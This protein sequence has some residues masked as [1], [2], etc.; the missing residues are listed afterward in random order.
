M[1]DSKLKTQH[2][3][4]PKISKSTMAPLRRP[5][6]GARVPNRSAPSLKMWVAISIFLVLAVLFWNPVAVVEAQE[7]SVLENG[8]E[9]KTDESFLPKENGLIVLDSLNSLRQVFQQEYSPLVLT[10]VY[11]SSCPHSLALLNRVEVAHRILTVHFEQITDAVGDHKMPSFAKLDA[12]D[13]D[14]VHLQQSGVFA[15][16]TLVFATGDDSGHAPFVLEYTGQQE[17]AEDI[18]RTVLHYFHQLI[19]AA[20]EVDR[21]DDFVNVK[22]REFRNMMDVTDFMRDQQH[23]ILGNTVVEPGFPST[24]SAELRKY[25]SWLMLDEVADDFVLIVQCRN[26]QSE[27]SESRPYYKSFDH[28]VLVISSRRDRLFITLSECDADAIDGSVVAWKIPFGVAR[29]GER[30]LSVPK[31]TFSLSPRSDESSDDLSLELIEFVVKVSTPSLLWFD[32]QAT[33][34]I[35]FPKYRQ[36]HAVLFVDLHHVEGGFDRP[37]AVKSREMI[38]RFRQTCREHWRKDD[39]AEQ[40]MVCLVVPSTETR[41]LA[42]F[43]IDIWSVLDER[44]QQ[45]DSMKEMTEP[46]PALMLTD[47]RSGGTRRYYLD[48]NA[49]SASNEAIPDFVTNFWQGGLTPHTKSS[50]EGPRTNA[51][52]VRIVTGDSLRSEILQADDDRHA[53]IFFTSPTCGHCKRFSILWNQLAELIAHVEWDSFLTLYQ[54]DVTANDIID[55]DVITVRWLPDV[56]FF[57]S[58]N[59]TNPLRYDVTDEQGEGVGALG[60]P[61]EILHWLIQEGDFEDAQLRQML[62]GLNKKDETTAK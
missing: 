56:Y 8:E 14:P 40:D 19:L 55:L 15:F 38:R 37:S 39:T 43:G 33:A 57:S 29:S 6:T 9:S 41:V 46:L 62:L 34:P 45:P 11:S 50:K 16:P 30:E 12:I 10:L 1:R 58:H 36:A 59:R 18:Y 54:M 51:S 22:P 61:L 60:K 25:I 21:T 7:D 13:S 23:G 24:I 31:A 27:E 28:M 3:K 20:G 5:S 2:N 52:G 48:S 32:R 42:T 4:I 47:Q 26:G 49:L 44:V 53:L 35:A 17:T